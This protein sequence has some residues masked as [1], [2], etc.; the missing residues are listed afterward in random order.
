M[1]LEQEDAHKNS[2]QNIFPFNIFSVTNDDH[3][4]M[5]KGIFHSEHRQNLEGAWDDLLCLDT[6]V[7][8]L[9]MFT[10]NKGPS[11]YASRTFFLFYLC[12]FRIFSHTRFS[13]FY[14]P[15]DL[16]LYSFHKNILMFLF[17]FSM[18]TTPGD[19]NLWLSTWTNLI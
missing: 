4:D 9:T 18:Q 6:A 16:N 10:L 11:T 7:N 17:F 12:A 14:D 15:P 19:S 1:N 13:M 5:C 3:D 2:F 8:Y